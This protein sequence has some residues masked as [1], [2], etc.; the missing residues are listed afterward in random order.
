[1][2]ISI[3]TVCKNSEAHIE[4]AITSVISQTYK[5]I[6]YIIIDGNSQDRTKEIIQQYSNHITYF[7]SEPD[8]GIYEAMNK[9]IEIATGSFVQFLNSDDYLYDNKVIEDLADFIQAHPDCQIIYGDSHIRPNFR[10]SSESYIA[11]PPLPSEITE[12]LVYGVLFL[13]GSMFFKSEIFSTLGLFSTHYKISADYEFYTRFLS[14]T[15]LKIY[16]YSRIIFSFFMG[17]LAGSSPHTTLKEMFTI[18]NQV[19]FFQNDYWQ[20][21]RI[22]KFQNA[23]V[24]LNRIL[25][26]TQSISENRRLFIQKLKNPWLALKIVAKKAL[27]TV[28]NAKE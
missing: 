13:Q 11:K 2:K 27:T 14:M 23:I 17:G 24:E 9:G 20:S 3:I 1:M 28:F 12:S 7:I 8:E 4:K 6:E 26:D 25:A 16:Y 5:D 18:Q 21:Q 19:D 22:I 15:D 10:I